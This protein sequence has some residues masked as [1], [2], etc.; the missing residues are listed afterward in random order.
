[1][2]RD[3]T[4]ADIPRL[5]GRVVLVT[6]A[7]SGI[8]FETAKELARHGAVVVLACRDDDK[9]ASAA[10]SIVESYPYAQVET[11]H[12]DL[13][14][15]A[16][17]R[18][19]ACRFTERHSRLDVLINNAG[20][21]GTPAQRSADGFE[22]QFATNHLGH[23]ALTGLLLD[24]LLSTPASR[25][26]T[27]SSLGHRLARIDLA[28]LHFER[29]RYRRFR[30]YGNSKLANLLFTYELH[31]R[32][33]TA[34]GSTLAVA[35]HPGGARTNLVRMRPGSREAFVDRILRASDAGAPNAAMGALA[36]LRAATDPEVAGGE[37]Y[38]P[39]GRMQASG[40][41]VRVESNARSRDDAL[42]RELWKISEELTGIAILS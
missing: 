10:D 37:Y 16:S 6:G 34:G 25:A 28:D 22:R 32:L 40:P 35:A 36:I 18:S 27:V 33:S 24:T 7:N 42:A 26:V 39:A 21:M 4:T 30:A 15:L 29:R 13:A 8:G 14:A 12:L 5:S 17:V 9:A 41:P 2:T 11:L 23:F 38:G 3:W 19:G 20:I 31:R 1:M